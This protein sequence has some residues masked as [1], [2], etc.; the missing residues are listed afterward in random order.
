LFT[1]FFPFGE[2]GVPGMSG[3]QGVQGMGTGGFEGFS[4]FPSS[5]LGR[6]SSSFEDIPS[7]VSRRKK[8]QDPPIEKNIFVSLEE[9]LNGTQK[10][11]RI[12]RKV[13]NPDGQTTRNEEKILTLDVKKGWKAGT[14]I[15]FKKEGDQG[16]NKIPAD[17]IFVIRDKE[18]P[19][20]QRDSDNNVLY[21]AK[22]SLRSALTGYFY[23]SSVSVPT[24]DKRTINVPLNDIIKPGTRKR[25]KSEG[26]PLPKRP[27]QRADLMVTFEVVFPTSLTKDNVEALQRAL[28]P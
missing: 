28:P 11:L 16:P 24:L 12:M 9:L 2:A 20:F 27:T 21:T 23:G 7:R 14:K 22:I 10:K 26:L 19:H 25:I 3:M 8:N 18:H 13:L 5:R 17:I 1:D 15:T 6:R 4:G